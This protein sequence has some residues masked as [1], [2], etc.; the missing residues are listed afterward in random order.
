MF[1]S[2]RMLS[3]GILGGDFFVS[4][5][6]TFQFLPLDVK[7]GLNLISLILLCDE[8]CNS[9]IV[10]QHACVCVCVCVCDRGRDREREREI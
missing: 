5:F 8:N 7:G 4:F 9:L 10:A 1:C 2:S 3:A 6:F